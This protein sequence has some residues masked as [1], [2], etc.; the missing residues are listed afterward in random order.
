MEHVET[1]GNKDFLFFDAH[2]NMMDC[3][4]KTNIILFTKIPSLEGAERIEIARWAILAKEPACRG[5][6]WW[7][8]EMTTSSRPCARYTSRVGATGRAEVRAISGL[9]SH[10][11]SIK[12]SF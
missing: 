1:A 10:P 6:L 3:L 11:Y 9:P 4:F 12:S 7:A 2:R 5:D 8:P